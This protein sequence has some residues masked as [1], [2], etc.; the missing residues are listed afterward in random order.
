MS[1]TSTPI[2][3]LTNIHTDAPKFQALSKHFQD[4]V[5]LSFRKALLH[6]GDPQTFPLDG[7][8][9]S[10]EAVFAHT[11]QAVPSEKKATAI[12]SAL[13]GAKTMPAGVPSQ[14]SL[15]TASPIQ[16]QM[17]ALPLPGR[18]TPSELAQMT[19]IVTRPSVNQPSAPTRFQQAEIRL[20]KLK[21]VQ[22]TKEIFEGLDEP[23]L[24]AV[25]VRQ[26]K[27]SSQIGPVTFG[28]FDEG[29]EKTFHPPIRFTTIPF[30][31]H[32]QFP[33]ALA[34]TFSF[35]E[36]DKDDA[37]K[38]LQTV[39]DAVK[40]VKGQ[41]V[42]AL[43]E[44]L[45]L[46]SDGSSSSTDAGTTV[47][48]V[49]LNVVVGAVID[50]IGKLLVDLVGSDPFTPTMTAFAISSGDSTDSADEQVTFTSDHFKGKYVLTYDL[51]LS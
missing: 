3:M 35:I 48:V 37:A 12:K 31:S 8:K 27:T 45:G 4:M 32:D 22:K 20:L 9:P 15:R 46:S 41:I 28:Q 50:L 13:A 6:E 24:G 30:D 34:V 1:T 36:K 39:F 17:Q 42:D 51:H 21:C 33:Q 5:E 23:E 7:E 14:V 16:E 25:L 47:L 44:L 2:T 43:E 10:L 18:L 26:D 40:A 19:Q 29:Q 38:I 49:L 11:L